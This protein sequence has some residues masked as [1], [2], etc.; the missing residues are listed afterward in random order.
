MNKIVRRTILDGETPE[1]CCEVII[2]ELN[3]KYDKFQIIHKEYKE[4]IIPESH[5]KH[6]FIEVIIEMI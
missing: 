5:D 3:D 4:N 1:Q 6:R 2:K